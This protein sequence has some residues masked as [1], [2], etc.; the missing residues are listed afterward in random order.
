MVIF[1]PKLAGLTAISSSYMI[2]ETT[3]SLSLNG[4]EPAMHWNKQLKE[5]INYLQSH[6][7]IVKQ[8]SNVYYIIIHKAYQIN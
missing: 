3:V 6:L 7:E 1:Y 2:K 8:S 4:K 5:K